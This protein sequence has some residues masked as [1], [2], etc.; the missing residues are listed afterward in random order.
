MAG[1][2][3][4]G[5]EAQGNSSPTVTLRRFAISQNVWPGDFNGDGVTDLAG[6][7]EPSTPG[8]TGRVIVMIGNGL[9]DFTATHVTGYV[10]HVLGV[11][12]FNADRRLDLVVVDPFDGNPAILPGDG[13]GSFDA[14]RQVASTDEV[15]FALSSDLDGDGKRDLVV[16]AEGTSVAVY[17]GNG[18][19][20]FAPETTLAV[21]ASPRDGII[22][23]LN[24]DGKK[25]LVVANHYAHSV[26]VLLNQGAM[27]FAG[28]DVPLITGNG[29]DVTVGDVNR[30][31]KPDIVLA[32]S[33]G[34]DGDFW[35][36]AGHAEV[37]LGS[38][39]GTFTG[40]P[41]YEVPRGAWQV[42]VGDFTRDGNIDIATANRSSI[43]HDD[44]CGTF[45][46]TWDSVSVL[47]GRA[48]GSFGAP[49]SFS[50][51]NQADAHVDDDTFKNHVRTLNTSDVNRD[52]ATDLIVSSGVV[53][54][55]V[56]ADPNWA[57]TVDAGPDQHIENVYE[58]MLTARAVDDDQ[59]ML[60]W[61]WR[62]AAGDA[63]A[64]WPQLCYSGLHQG[65]NVFT[66][67]VDDGH[68]H[69]TSDSV[70]VTVDAGTTGGGSTQPT[71]T[72]LAPVEG[73]TIP[74]GQPYT[75]RFHIDDPNTMLNTWSVSYSVD[76]GATWEYI[77]RAFGS[78]SGPGVA[79]SR[80]DSC[81]W[82][83]PGPASTQ[84]MIAVFAQGD[85][86]SPI[87]T[88]SHAR[89]TISPQPGGVA[90]PWQQQD[91]GTVAK[92]GSTTYSNGVYT[93][94]ASGADIWDNADEFRFTYQ[95]VSNSAIVVTAR[96]DS[97]QNV[98]QW[99]KAGV[100]IRAGEGAAAPHASLFVT[101][102]KGIAFQRRLS[103][104]GTSL[105][106]QVLSVTAPA[107][108]KLVSQATGTTETVRAYYRKN[109]SDP[110]ILAGEDTFPTVISQRSA[111]LALSSH[112]DGTLAKAVFS[113][114]SIG[115]ITDWSAVSVG[116]TAGSA[117]WNDR[118]LTLNVS[119]ADIWGAS[120][121][122]EYAYRDCFRDCTITAR[123][124]SLQNTNQWAKAG[125]MIRESTGTGARHVDIIV[126]PSKGV[127]MQ[128]RSATGGISAGA[129]SAAGVAP[130]WV[131][132]QR[133]GNAFV[134]YWSADGISFAEVGSITVPM[135]E[136]VLVG[137]AATS[138]DTASATT[139]VFED[140]A[141]A[142]P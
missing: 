62:D 105:S 112:A 22:S 125:V 67:T 46:K 82:R 40:G 24:G 140:L 28:A 109:A 138:H 56:E 25:D 63:I 31:G 118:Q 57:P 52:G 32:T 21:N 108:L 33:D 139:A 97:V 70:T 41:S 58:T 10:G 79:T 9:G 130:G 74:A 3:S 87:G 48:D 34:G 14:P 110:W 106:T 100:M 37:L 99:T 18:D 13:T 136:A 101:P 141:I 35:F 64:H 15:T 92:P 131:R 126:S 53:L 103:T 55:N 5:V 66:V 84:A 83:N 39:D 42:V 132:L 127:A 47:P 26:T 44:G 36:T 86:N 23:D 116:T 68:G 123:V 90:Y 81:E 11:G 88:Q 50:L 134:G 27:Q 16:G 73:A 38:G 133:T 60:T 69:V 43:T 113:G 129:G 107:W 102:G 120:D 111:G 78:S 85:D 98:N 137:V 80:D 45:W 128:Y 6:S 65:D 17:P 4:W 115:R 61:T 91:I 89:I 54:F 8:G 75:V 1:L 135:N 94:N 51:A 30:D 59:D 71:M 2:G 117:T 104:G 76:N 119:G 7:E 20:T 29:N 142:Q 72:L 124:A 77:C 19:F 122:F 114:V 12:D 93:M 95:A 96:V 121:Q 49:S